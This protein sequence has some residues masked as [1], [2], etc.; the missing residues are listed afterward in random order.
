MKT[1]L[2][3]LLLKILNCFWRF[4]TYQTEWVEDL[5]EKT[6]KDTIYIVGGREH[7]YYAAVVCPRHSCKRVISLEISKKSRKRWKMVE[8]GN[9]S[10]TLSPSIYVTRRP[11]KC[12]YWIR[13]GKVTWADF[14]P[15]FVPKSNTM[16]EN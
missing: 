8:H 9:G 16:P 13:R 6:G 15:V 2:R 4:R 3:K 14:P 12:H 1:T 5:P 10:L 7:P 11:C